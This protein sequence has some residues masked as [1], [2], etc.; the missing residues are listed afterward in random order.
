MVSHVRPPAAPTRAL[1]RPPVSPRPESAQK[2]IR[3]PREYKEMRG[4]FKAQRNRKETNAE[5][6]TNVTYIT[7][8]GRFRRQYQIGNYDRSNKP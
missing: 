5:T 2:T 1:R 4:E 8:L 3:K 7:V 6:N